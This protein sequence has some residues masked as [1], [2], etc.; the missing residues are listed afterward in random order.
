MCYVTNWDWWHN[1]QQFQKPVTYMASTQFVTSTLI[2]DTEWY[3]GRNNNKMTLRG[4]LCGYNFEWIT[5]ISQ[6]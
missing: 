4:D 6:Y 1:V 5:S 2:S 3:V